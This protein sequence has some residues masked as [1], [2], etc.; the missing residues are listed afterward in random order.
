MSSLS[1]SSVDLQDNQSNQP[2]ISDRANTSPPIIRN[3]LLDPNPS[4]VSVSN[5]EHSDSDYSDP[6]PPAW[7]QATL[8]LELTP[9]LYLDLLELDRKCDPKFF[10]NNKHDESLFLTEV[11]LPFMAMCMVGNFTCWVT[12]LDY[13]IVDSTWFADWGF[14]RLFLEAFESTLTR[15]PYPRIFNICNS[16]EWLYELHNQSRNIAL[17][18]YP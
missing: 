4:N 16:K 5:S 10:Y 17:L 7:P 12:Q 11:L 14:R 9:N 6:I 8:N 13:T 18:K 1:S 2:S 15:L 3:I